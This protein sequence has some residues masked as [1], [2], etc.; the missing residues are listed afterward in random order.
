MYGQGPLAGRNFFDELR[1]TMKWQMPAQQRRRS[2]FDRCLDKL[3]LP[4]G[5]S[6]VIE[7]KNAQ[8]TKI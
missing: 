8:I 2:W 3:G 1:V 6:G 5:R 7:D 4:A